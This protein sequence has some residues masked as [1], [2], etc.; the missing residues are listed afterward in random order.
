LVGW[1]TG[2]NA[3]ETKDNVE[4]KREEKRET[5]KKKEPCF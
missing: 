5:R 2:T 1:H 4:S 3:K